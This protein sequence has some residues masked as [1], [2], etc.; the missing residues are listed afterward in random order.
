MT[1]ENSKSREEASGQS[2]PCGIYRTTIAIE[3]KVPAG[4]LV[5]YHNH[6]D[7]GPGVYPVERW[8]QNRAIFSK[9][10][11]L[12]PEGE[13]DAT[14]AT[15]HP[16]GFYRVEQEFWCCEKHCRRY[17][18]GL[19]VQLG[20]NGRAE[21]ILFLPVW[22][23]SGLDLPKQGNRI[24]DENLDRL[25]PLKVVDHFTSKDTQKKPGP[26]SEDRGYLH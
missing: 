20:Y 18:P 14:L 22:S 8:T 23:E 3:E 21:P 12:A 25:S 15:L 1:E 10:G 7:P 5:Y 24:D 4:A 9:R 11:V 19:M 16:E 13:W 17:E 6:G 2:R 26:P